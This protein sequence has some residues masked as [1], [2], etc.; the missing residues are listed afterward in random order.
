MGRVAEV[1]PD[2]CM[3]LLLTGQD[4]FCVWVRPGHRSCFAAEGLGAAS[5]SVN[6]SSSSIRRS[7]PLMGG[8]YSTRHLRT[9]TL[10]MFRHLGGGPE[11]AQ[12]YKG[13]CA[14]VLYHPDRGHG[15]TLALT[16][17]SAPLPNRV[18]GRRDQRA[19]AE[20][21]CVRDGSG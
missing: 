7:F 3:P 8:E 16:R 15:V 21:Y 11:G 13:Y 2:E 14:H 19:P 10:L 9:P 12:P 18:K 20:W 5:S 4:A 6:R 17:S 1:T